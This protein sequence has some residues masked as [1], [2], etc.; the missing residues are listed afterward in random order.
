M[1][2]Y[3]MITCEWRGSQR[4]QYVSRTAKRIGRAEYVSWVM[5]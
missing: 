1:R 3:I 4:C 2:R 5:R